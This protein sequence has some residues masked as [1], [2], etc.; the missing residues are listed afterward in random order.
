VLR[1]VK[2][3]NGFG[4]KATDGGIGTIEGFIL[5]DAGWIVRYLVILHKTWWRDRHAVLP[6]FSVNE[7]DEEN[8][9]M[10]VD[11]STRRIKASPG[12]SAHAPLTRVW[13]QE[14]FSYYGWMGYWL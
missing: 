11:V 6:P 1:S 8:H 4:V 7:I 14:F 3:L 5:D 2:A 13:E 10:H 12:Y 9:L